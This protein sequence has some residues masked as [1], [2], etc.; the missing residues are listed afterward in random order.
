MHRHELNILGPYIENNRRQKYDNSVNI[1]VYTLGVCSNSY[2]TFKEFYLHHIGISQPQLR[3]VR[4][5]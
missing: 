4:Y 2:R 3:F 1:K 5:G